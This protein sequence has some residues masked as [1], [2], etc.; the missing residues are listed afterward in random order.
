MIQQIHFSIPEELSRLKRQTLEIPAPNQQT[1]LQ[2]L[3]FKQVF[4]SRV[5]LHAAQSIAQVAHR[6]RAWLIR[7]SIGHW[8]AHR[9]TNHTWESRYATK[10]QAYPETKG[11]KGNINTVFFLNILYRQ[12][13]RQTDRHTHTH[14]HRG[15][16]TLTHSHT[17]IPHCDTWTVIICLKRHYIFHLFK[18][19]SN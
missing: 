18:F 7:Q 3:L 14:T 2:F 5:E 1:Y 19:P 16:Q 11:E 6:I 12:T 13:N 9:C 4:W 8:P 15:T 10:Q 17:I